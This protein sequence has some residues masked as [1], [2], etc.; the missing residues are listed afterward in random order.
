[1]A[2][3]QLSAEDDDEII[4]HFGRFLQVLAEKIGEER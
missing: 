1:V 2:G 3:R 4:E